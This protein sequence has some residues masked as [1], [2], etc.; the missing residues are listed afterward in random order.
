MKRNYKML[1]TNTLMRENN[2]S[3]V[4]TQIINHPE[5][6]RAEIA[7]ST[8]LNKATVS[9]I[10]R[11]LIDKHYILETGIGES[12]FGGGR[13]PILLKTNKKAGMSFSFDIRFDRV[14]YMACY[15]DGEVIEMDSFDLYI[16][17]QNIVKIISD[18]VK[19]YQKG[20]PQTPYGIV[21]ITIAVHGIVSNNKIVYTPYYDISALN[22]VEI[23][24]NELDIP[25]YLENEAN[26]TALAESTLDS[27]H[28]NLITLSIHTG[29]GAGIIIN[30]NLY[31]GYEGRS[32][33][34]GHT[35]LYPD[36]IQCT[37]G[38]NGCLEQYCSETSLLKFFRNAHQNLSLTTDDLVKDYK[39]QDPIA[40]ELIEDFA[41]NLS[42]GI[43]N[44]AGMYGPQVVYLSGSIIN[45]LP[46]IVDMILENLESTIYKWLPVKVSKIMEDSALH[47]A[48]ITNI[49]Y[50]FG[51]NN[52][53]LSKKSLHQFE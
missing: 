26:L 21:G 22:L 10:V 36:G 41:K 12:S 27:Q 52:I 42:I 11:D 25:V 13:R 7:K 23:L 9:E 8:Q 51:V 35:T 44:L 39:N 46:S 34:I 1:K 28:K 6:S 19:D 30:D 4:I 5:I 14:S 2:V 43:I 50:F 33:E 32:G 15:L 3:T 18:I 29:V 17:S 20:M 37:C 40:V 48:T 16:D 24:T 31:R 38:N 49:Q 45:K 53:N 47:G